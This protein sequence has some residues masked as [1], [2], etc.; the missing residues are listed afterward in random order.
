MTIARHELVDPEITRYYHCVGRCVRRAFLCGTDHFS[1]QSYEHRRQWVVDRLRGLAEVFA[2]DVCAYA[3][4]SNH[5]HLVLK[6]APERVER[7]SDDEVETRWRR[8]FRLAPGHALTEAKRAARLPLWRERLASLSW[9][10]RCSGN[11]GQTPIPTASATWRVAAAR[12]RI[13]TAMIPT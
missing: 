4:M 2:V 8:L 7:W 5:Y 13:R 3:V 9:F 10:M 1:G 11:R 6:L 12:G